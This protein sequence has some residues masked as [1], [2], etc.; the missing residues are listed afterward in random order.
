[1][2][3]SLKV[4]ATAAMAFSM[5]TSV[6]MA[7]GT[8]M[9][10]TTS[11]SAT[12]AATKTSA[13]FKDLSNLD[14][15]LK[16][17]IDALLSKGVF[18]GV[19]ADSFGITQ[20]MT[21]AQFA[22]VLVLVFGIKVDDKVKTSSFSD[23]KA[24]DTANSWAIPFIEAAKKAGLIDGLSDT[25][26]A[27]G[28]NVT[29]G[30]FATVLVKGLGK[31]V[32]FTGTPWYKDAIDQAVALKILPEGTDG[33]KAATRADLV[34]G[35]Y[36]GVQAY[37]DANKPAKVSVTEAKAAG[38]QTVQVT[39]TRD[40]DTSKA[41][42]TLKKGDT[43]INTTTKFSDDKKSAT[44]T[45]TDLKISDGE[46]TVTLG[47][48]D[49]AV[50]DTATAK[51]TAQNETVS[52][53]E[54]VSANDTLAYSAN[55]S[56]NLKA[57][58]QYGEVASKGAS[59]Y[60]AFV[61]GATAT[62]TGGDGNL[63]IK[64][65]TKGNSFVQGQSMISVTVYYNDNRITAMKTFKLGTAPF[66]SKVELGDAKYSNGAKALT[67]GDNVVIPMKLYDQYGNPIVQAQF[68]GE[69]Q[70]SQI[71]A[72][73]APYD[74][75]LT[76]NI[77]KLFDTDGNLQVEIDAATK[78]DK[79]A[80]YTVSVYAGS[81]SATAKVSVSAGN[82]ATKVD[83]GA[84]TDVIAAGDTVANVPLIVT[85]A[86]G[87]QLSTQDIVDNASRFTFSA[88]NTDNT[89]PAPGIVKSGSNKGKLQINID[90]NAKANST[91]YVTAL[92]ANANVNSYAQL[93]IPIQEKRMPD[94]LAI[95]T[96]PA[97]KAI[98]GAGSDVSFTLKDQYG[99]DIGSFGNNIPNANGQTANYQV[100]VSISGDS[101]VTSGVYLV[102]KGATAVTLNDANPSFVFNGSNVG[103]FNGGFTFKTDSTKYGSLTIKAVLQK[104]SGT[105]FADHSTTV[106]RTLQAVK[107]DA[108]L[109]YS[110]NT[111]NTLY[112]AEDNLTTINRGI[113]AG[114]GDSGTPLTSLYRAK[115][116]VTVKD[117]SG[118]K[119]AVPGNFVKGISSTNL[120]IVDVALDS[121]NNEGYI[122]GNKAGTATVTAVVYT[123]NN[124]ETVALNQSVT[125]KSDAIVVDSLTAGNSNANYTGKTFAY[126]LF[127]HLDVKDQYGVTY[128]D[129][130]ITKFNSL[131]GLLY[132]VSGVK[133]GGSV[134]LDPVNGAFSTSGTVN[135]FIITATANGKSVQVLVKP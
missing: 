134:T 8:V 69:V 39:L 64:T 99:G 54:F 12:T 60:S 35:A 56:I 96:E 37:A 84:F 57:T 42:L 130:N 14:A 102:A 105:G 104:D 93:S 30:Q 113:P 98:L 76:Y 21:R 127:N 121:I 75:N 63:T 38:V 61:N 34:S 119:V 115:L 51:F 111:I 53:I 27:P 95:G 126:Q 44:L 94:H 120:S 114:T 77:G 40:V 43:P 88:S 85:D 10:S 116:S 103:D 128:E 87:K 91:V 36:G 28:D 6:A 11:T 49:A 26:F 131:I 80:D 66:I 16:A 58:N 3:K 47:G 62:I 17:K 55:V 81:S 109:I 101:T 68:P 106:S 118:N 70:T 52:K 117:S 90:P 74:S 9:T 72:I 112:A 79:A 18:E 50:V 83:F 41:T 129:A 123:T 19:S 97:A 22:K 45:L 65:T 59:G 32:D 110:L 107:P 86:N 25:T 13:D 78:E 31:K 71:N 89:K 92:I 24:D 100:K 125:V 1:M 46:Y 73:I 135:E 7:D 33:S 132:T 20:N 124:G 67:G 48:L 108:S 15:T 23:V 5:F 122:L 133:G 4:I 29:L 82:L 2:K